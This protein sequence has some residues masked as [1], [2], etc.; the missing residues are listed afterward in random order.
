MPVVY[1]PEDLQISDRML[2]ARIRD[3]DNRFGL[4]CTRHSHRDLSP[5]ERRWC[6]EAQK[7]ADAWGPAVFNMSLIWRFKGNLR[8]E[9]L[10]R[11]AEQ[12][13]QRH[14]ILGCTLEFV[15]G[16]W[17]FRADRAP[18]VSVR[19]L[20]GFDMDRGESSAMRAVS[21]HIYREFDFSIEGPLRVGYA[22]VGDDDYIVAAAFHHSFADAYSKRILSFELAALYDSLDRGLESQLMPLPLSYLDYLRSVQ[23]WITTPGAQEVARFWMRRLDGV[24]PLKHTRAEQVSRSSF[25]LAEEVSAR[26]RQL[27]STLRVGV[28]TFWE[29]AH[30]LVLRELAGRQDVAT[31]SVD[32]G[33]RQEELIGV[34]GQFVNLY[35]CCSRL[36]DD[37]TFSDVVRN[38]QAT[39]RESAP[40]RIVPYDLIADRCPFEYA[41]SFGHLNFIPRQFFALPTFGPLASCE[42]PAG[43]EGT[44]IYPYAISV[45][46]EPR[47]LVRCTGHIREP[48]NVRELSLA[49]ERVAI[50]CVSEP[51]LEL[52]RVLA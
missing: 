27:C 48:F 26:V 28:H 1:D 35:P 13:V 11:A 46:D 19:E 30:H 8:P 34:F 20:Q 31:L 36:S 12:V 22:R 39:N 16:G 50:A 2:R 38:L 7:P 37:L 24:M 41:A 44:F 3:P 40:Y 14:S 51:D 4:V 9:I 32:G 10:Q 29:A 6:L 21:E 17:R 33:R 52:A 42:L 43:T 18:Q 5:P 47:F 49:L 25:C 45:R 23:E 15:E